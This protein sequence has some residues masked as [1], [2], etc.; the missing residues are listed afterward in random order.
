MSKSK[1]TPAP[2]SAPRRGAQTQST[3]SDPLTGLLR[4][5]V[6]GLILVRWLIPTES[7]PGGETLWIVQLDF[8][9]VILWVW[10][11]LRSGNYAVRW[12]LFDCALWVLVAAHCL[13][14]AF[15]FVTGGDRRTALNL[16]W[17]WVGL[18]ATFFLL[19]QTIQT[20]LD[21]RRLASMVVAL[22]VVLSGLGIWQH[23]VYYRMASREYSEMM[24]KLDALQKDPRANAQELGKLVHAAI[25]GHSDR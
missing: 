7:A 10:S 13:S 19:R 14:A 3:V 12:S 1:R 21:A 8:A 25:A 4:T 6:I 24:S 22:A 15:V 17:E 23:Y 16:A 11:C 20:A 5:L 18:G 2:Q 9:A